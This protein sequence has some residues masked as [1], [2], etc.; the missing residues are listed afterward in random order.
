MPLDL[1]CVRGLCSAVT[2]SDLGRA[3]HGDDVEFGDIGVIWVVVDG[4][5]DGFFLARDGLPCFESSVVVM[6]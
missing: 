6:R 4:L 3:V 1:S 2:K 5:H